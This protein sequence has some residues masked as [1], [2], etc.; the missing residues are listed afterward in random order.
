M[1]V[2]VT[3]CLLSRI[4]TLCHTGWW[5]GR[6]AV[7]VHFII[8]VMT[9]IS[10]EEEWLPLALLTHTP[11]SHYCQPVYSHQYQLNN[12]ERNHFFHSYRRTVSKESKTK[13]SEGRKGPFVLF[14]D[15]YSTVLI[16]SCKETCSL[17]PHTQS[18]VCKTTAEIS[19][20]SLHRSRTEVLV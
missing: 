6:Q 11:P 17:I 7:C 13:R 3:V 5:A 19:Q 2:S 14:S 1:Y 4:V 9:G 18:A 20:M 10:S 16:I 15:S 12:S 8:S